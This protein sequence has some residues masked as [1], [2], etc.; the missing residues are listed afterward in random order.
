LQDLGLAHL[1]FDLE[2]EFAGPGQVVFPLP[3][4]PALVFQEAQVLLPGQD[5]VG[6]NFAHGKNLSSNLADSNEKG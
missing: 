1:G 2:Q 3:V 5:A 4:F 6:D